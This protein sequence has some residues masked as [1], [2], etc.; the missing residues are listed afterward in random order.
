MSARKQLKLQQAIKLLNLKLA[1]YRVH[2]LPVTPT[3][4]ASVKAKGEVSIPFFALGKSASP[5]EE[6]VITHISK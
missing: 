3:Q 1:A 2:A 4:S 5:I 6:S